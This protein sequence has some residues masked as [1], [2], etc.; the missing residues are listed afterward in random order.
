M[1]IAQME[2]IAIIVK[3]QIIHVTFNFNLHGKPQSAQTPIKDIEIFVG[4]CLLIIEKA[5]TCAREFSI[6]RCM[7]E[8]TKKVPHH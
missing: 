2:I 3:G 7:L 4:P 6:Y 5:S 1:V 8:A